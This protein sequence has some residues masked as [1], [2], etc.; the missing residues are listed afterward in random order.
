MSLEA[1]EKKQ[2]TQRS[3]NR[4]HYRR[5]KT[6]RRKKERVDRVPAQ[7][8]LGSAAVGGSSNGVPHCSATWLGTA[9]C[10]HGRTNSAL[11]P[12]PLQTLNKAP[13]SLYLR[14]GRV[15]N[16]LIWILTTP[17]GILTWHRLCY[18]ASQNCVSGASSPSLFSTTSLK[19][20]RHPISAVHRGR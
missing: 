20:P 17:G 18:G 9:R 14:A 15:E 13:N 1:C 2:K 10:R 19:I 16:V 8:N 3:W 5:C 6:L 11:E 4:R 12:P 7:R